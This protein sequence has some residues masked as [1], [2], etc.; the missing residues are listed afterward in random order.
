MVSRAG[1]IFTLFPFSPYRRKPTASLL[2]CE[3]GLGR[4]SGWRHA[5]S[6]ENSNASIRQGYVVSYL[7]ASKE[8]KRR[9]G[10]RKSLCANNYTGRK[11][12]APKRESSPCKA[13]GRLAWISPANYA[14]QGQSRPI[15]Q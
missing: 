6:V 8:K 2:F 14:T 9:S 12:K 13:Q 10:L 5:R 15:P 4:V 11:G 3:Q 1:A 7:Q